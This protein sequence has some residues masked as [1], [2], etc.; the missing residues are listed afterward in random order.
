MDHPRRQIILDVLK[1]Q[2]KD[3]REAYLEEVAEEIDSQW[4]VLKKRALTGYDGD[5]TLTYHLDSGIYILLGRPDAARNAAQKILRR[6]AEKDV[7]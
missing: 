6:M 3:S 1:E 7:H 4:H 2:Y 5:W